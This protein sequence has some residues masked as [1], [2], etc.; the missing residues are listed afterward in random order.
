[1]LMF[2]IFYLVKSQSWVIAMKEIKMFVIFQAQEK[3]Y[4]LQ[5]KKIYFV[6][7]EAANV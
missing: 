5:T 7:F 2:S 6:E 4:F 1:M 3:M